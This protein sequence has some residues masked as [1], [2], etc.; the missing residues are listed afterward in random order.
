MYHLF[1][2]QKSAANSSVKISRFSF[3]V[4]QRFEGRNDS[5]PSINYAGGG[6]EG[7]GV[8]HVVAGQDR[9]V[10]NLVGPIT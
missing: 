4:G 6:P 9:V 8:H 5:G 10:V 7:E 2:L 1:T 3:V